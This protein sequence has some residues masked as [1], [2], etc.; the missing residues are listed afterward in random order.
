MGRTDH[1]FVHVWSHFNRRPHRFLIIIC[2]LGKSAAIDLSKAT[3][4]KNAVFQ[5]TEAGVEWITET[6]RT[7]IPSHP[8]LRQITIRIRCTFASFIVKEESAAYG[9][10]LDL[11]RLLVQFLESCPTRQKVICTTLSG[12]KQG[13]TGFIE[14]LLP[15]LGRRGMIDLDE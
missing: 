8:E 6:L 14:Y 15:E 3:R 13:I 7:A 10:W 11:D 9:E 1:V 12:R 5:P 4:L 2:F